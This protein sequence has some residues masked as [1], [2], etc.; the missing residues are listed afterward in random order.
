MRWLHPLTLVTYLSK[1]LGT[2]RFA[3]FNQLG[4]FWGYF[5]SVGQR[6]KGILLTRNPVVGVFRSRLLHRIENV[7]RNTPSAHIMT[8]TMR[9]RIKSC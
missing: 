8:P 1:F 9:A 5:Q 4:L 2:H 6:S 7:L 3:A